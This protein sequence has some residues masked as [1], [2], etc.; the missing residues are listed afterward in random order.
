MGQRR[1]P[2]DKTVDRKADKLRKDL[3]QSGQY[4]YHKKD[5][6]R[7]LN[8]L[9]DCEEAPDTDKLLWGDCISTFIAIKNVIQRLGVRGSKILQVI[10][11]SVVACML[12]IKEDRYDKIYNEEHKAT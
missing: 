8:R 12:D 9:S 3:F 11:Q 7:L 1:S 5:I 4:Y 10:K 2:N 6:V